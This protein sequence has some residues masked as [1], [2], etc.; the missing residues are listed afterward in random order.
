MGT[1]GSEYQP[2][3]TEPSKGGSETCLAADFLPLHAKVL[4]SEGNV[5]VVSNVALVFDLHCRIQPRSAFTGK[6]TAR[7][8]LSGLEA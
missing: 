7:P 5:T 1:D 6:A 4:I 8:R 3:K 2:R